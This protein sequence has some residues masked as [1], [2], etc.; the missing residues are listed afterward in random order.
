[1][2]QRICEN[3][4]GNSY[5]IIEKIT[6]EFS[7]LMNGVELDDDDLVRIAAIKNDKMRTQWIAVRYVLKKFF[8]MDM[9]VSYTDRG[10]P[11]LTNNSDHISIS[12]S[13]EY[14]ALMLSKT[15]L[16]GVDIEQVH[17]RILKVREKFLSET[18]LA[19]IH[20]KDNVGKIM[21]YWNAK[22]ALYKLYGRRFLDFKREIEIFPFIQEDKGCFRGTIKKPGMDIQYNLRYFFIDDKYSVVYCVK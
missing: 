22:E 11:Y 20:D 4:D 16:V 13:N 14:I 6:N 1:M 2:I 12:H 3:I 8:G 5:L 17:D 9:K 19:G 18:E 15:N 10:K 7:F 21:L